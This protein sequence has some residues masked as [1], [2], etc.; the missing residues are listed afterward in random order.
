M[1]AS[2]P[3]YAFGRLA[4][5][6]GC[7][8]AIVALSATAVAERPSVPRLFPKSTVVL[9]SV[10]DAPDMARRLMNTAWGRMSQDPQMR[11]LFL[12]LYG[13]ALEAVDSVRD[14][15][16]LSLPEI[17]AIPQGELALAMVAPKRGTPKVLVLFDTGDQISKAA[18]LIDLAETA[19]QASGAIRSEQTVLGTKIVVYEGLD[20]GGQL[21]Y[22]VKDGTIVVGS[23][24]EIVATV[25]GVWN[26]SKGDV[27]ADNPHFAGVMRAS[28]D[29]AHKPQVFAYVD[30]INLMRS[31]GRENVGVQMGVAM[32]PVI[33]LDG[34][35]AV[36]GNLAL[37]TQDF[38][39]IAQVHV[40]LDPPRDGV[41]EIIA[42][43]PVDAMPD[44]W[45]PDDVS[46]YATLR[47]D[48]KTS[49][50]AF[51]EVFDGFRGEGALSNSLQPLKEGLKLDLEGELLPV[52]SGRVTFFN[53]IEKPI[54]QQSFTWLVAFEIR[55]GA[56]VTDL[57]RTFTQRNAAWL[58]EQ[59]H[60][61]KKF[62]QIGPPNRGQP[63]PG[64]PARPTPCMGLLEG[65]LVITDRVSM[66]QKAID[67][68]RHSSGKLAE[69][70]DFL[71]VLEKIRARPS[72]G[73]AAMIHFGQPRVGI[74]MFYEL[75][76]TQLARQQPNQQPQGDPVGRAINAALTQHGLPPFSAL[77]KYLAPTGAFLVDDASGI[78]LTRFSLRAEEPST[79]E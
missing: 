1:P 72:G 52:L 32:M 11:P 26:G 48:V 47:L 2:I 66:Y 61:G 16:G 46:H 70:A 49:F 17:L 79:A 35:A 37:D 24:P 21:A 3:S 63:M 60:G 23:D 39:T 55:P 75:A 18:G 71:A 67:T 40:L 14:Q 7:L 45:V 31:I 29:P 15:I 28:H 65:S 57:L 58:S 50:E 36:G 22:F 76:S 68:L 42:L 73:D 8:L 20:D 12:S 27:L 51:R 74:R 56:S 5:W 33:G 6:A 62:Y 64:A 30:P 41:L 25:L 34:L 10:V 4:S 59:S 54:S 19:I 78:H 13:S 9:V 69:S 44:A 77:E 43:K 38:D 53:R